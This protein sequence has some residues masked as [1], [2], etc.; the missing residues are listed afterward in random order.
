M[1]RYRILSSTANNQYSS[2]FDIALY[3]TIL[4]MNAMYGDFTASNLMLPMQATLVPSVVNRIRQSSFQLLG[5]H[6]LE[7]LGC[8]RSVTAVFSVGLAS[9][10]T[11]GVV[12]LVQMLIRIH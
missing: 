6:F 9:R 12:Y 7:T 5:Y 8:F 3:R 11:A 1:D 10:V 2:C 4:S